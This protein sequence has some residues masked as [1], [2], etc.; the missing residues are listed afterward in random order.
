ML[1][2]LAIGAARER[3]T[4]MDI[5]STLVKSALGDSRIEDGPC[6][7]QRRNEKAR[8]TIVVVMTRPSCFV[9][10]DFDAAL[11]RARAEGKLLVVDAVR[12]SSQM[13]QVMDR[14]TWSDA[15]VVRRLAEHTIAIRIDVDAEPA[16]AKRLDVRYPP[17]VVAVKDGAAIDR[18]TNV[19]KPEE[20]IAWLDGLARGETTLDRARAKAAAEPGD[21]V[22]RMHLA[23]RLDEAGLFDE[24]VR[25]CEHVWRHLVEA[26]LPDA[27]LMKHQVFARQLSDLFARH[28]PARAVFA[29]IRDEAKPKEDGEPDVEQLNDWMTL[30]ETLGDTAKTLAWWDAAHTK[31]APRPEVAEALE[32]RLVPLLVAAER[33]AN[34]GA[35][36]RDPRATLKWEADLMANMR[37]ISSPEGAVLAASG[38]SMA[39]LGPH[40]QPSRVQQEKLRTTAA[41]LVRAL[42]AANRT[43]DADGVTEDA[44][45]Y[46]DSPEM[47]EAVGAPSS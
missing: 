3:L 7:A 40:L 37:V 19:L 15:A 11:S 2:G 4:L 36:Y 46:D 35:L 14:V 1:A 24:S 26:G 6:P 8:D 34:A 20:L 13:T 9:D 42:R 16:L 38:A 44:L 31:L 10:L 47:R 41:H 33:W 28:P 32:K 43:A 23:S 25:E 21:I 29:R 45:R 17:T 22:R 5:V 27:G 30:N 12:S 39:A 18:V